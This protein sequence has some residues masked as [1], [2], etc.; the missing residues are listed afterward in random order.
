MEE[1]LGIAS[2]RHKTATIFKNTE[3]QLLEHMLSP[4]PTW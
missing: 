2:A 4:T 1:P 3:W